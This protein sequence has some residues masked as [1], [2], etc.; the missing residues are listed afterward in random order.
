[1]EEN[2]KMPKATE[3]R[4]KNAIN[5]KNLLSSCL[6]FYRHAKRIKHVDHAPNADAIAVVAPR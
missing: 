2:Q 6:F 1:V 4:T 3:E 5:D